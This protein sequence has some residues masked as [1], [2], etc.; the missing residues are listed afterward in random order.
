[1][2]L[3]RCGSQE[4]QFMVDMADTAWHQE[5]CDDCHLLFIRH[6]GQGTYEECG[7]LDGPYHPIN[8]PAYDQARDFIQSQKEDM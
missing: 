8:C 5:M 4:Y 3:P 6:D 7:V 1:M 2:G